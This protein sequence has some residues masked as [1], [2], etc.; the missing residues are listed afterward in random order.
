MII[1]VMVE[2][3]SF[4]RLGYCGLQGQTKGH[5]TVFTAVCGGHGNYNFWVSVMVHPSLLLQAGGTGVCERQLLGHLGTASKL[6]VY[7]NILTV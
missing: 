5:S 1:I 3:I 7:N 2:N 6:Y 4:F